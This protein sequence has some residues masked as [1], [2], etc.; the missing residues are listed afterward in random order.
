[1]SVELPIFTIEFIIKPE[2]LIEANHA[3]AWLDFYLCNIGQS[4]ALNVRLSPLELDD[5]SGMVSFRE[6]NYVRPGEKVKL[7]YSLE[8]KKSDPA[9]WEAQQQILYKI[10]LGIAAGENLRLV[11]GFEGVDGKDYSQAIVCREGQWYP[12]KP[13]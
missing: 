1:M 12:E 11:I 8:W 3:T 6:I 9:A 5:F 2:C 7:I 4:I 10:Q 13:R